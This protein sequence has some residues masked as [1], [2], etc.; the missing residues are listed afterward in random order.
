MRVMS[1]SRHRTIASTTSSLRAQGTGGMV[2][3]NRD[4]GLVVFKGLPHAAPPFDARAGGHRNLQS[5]VRACARPMRP[6]TAKGSHKKAPQPGGAAGPVE[7]RLGRT[8]ISVI[9]PGEG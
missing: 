8:C 2:E 6:G 4:G 9:T 7:G 5:H 1:R 3:G